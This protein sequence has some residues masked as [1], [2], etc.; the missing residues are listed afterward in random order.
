MP[1]ET[2]SQISNSTNGIEPTRGLITIKASKNGILSQIVPEVIS[3]NKNYEL[4]WDMPNNNGYLNLVGIM[5]KF[6][7]RSIN[8]SKY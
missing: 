4:L 6:I 7:D 5:Q 3:L 8:F 2:S 1:S